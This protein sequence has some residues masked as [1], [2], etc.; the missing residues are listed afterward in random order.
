M[1]FTV[2]FIESGDLGHQGIIGV[3]VREQRAYRQQHLR[4]GERGRPLVLQDVQANATT[5]V[6]VAMVDLGGE[7]HLGRLEGVV[8]GEVDVQEVHAAVVG[9]VLGAHDGGLP[10]EHVVA[11]GAG[12]AV[13]RRVSAQLRQ[14]AVDSLEGHS[15]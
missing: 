3:R 13:G 6:H 5:R 9:R 10:V 11:H 14:L 7:G 4:Y 2:R 15:D 1:F 8:C 12:R